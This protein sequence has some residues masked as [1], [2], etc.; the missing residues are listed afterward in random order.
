LY[1]V[2]YSIN[3]LAGYGASRHLVGILGARGCHLR[4]PVEC[5]ESGSTIIAGFD[6][7]VVD[8]DRYSW[9][10]DTFDFVVVLSRHRAESGRKTLSVHHPGNPT[11]EAYGGEPLKLAVAYPALAWKLLRVY[12]RLASEMG[13]EG[14]EVTLEATH[15]GP[16][17]LRP[18]VVFIEV[19]STELEWR[20]EK[21]REAMARAVAETL[22]EKLE[23]CNPVAAIGGPHYPARYTRAS[24][25]SSTCF[26]HI[27]A[28]H[29]IE[30]SSLESATRQAITRNYPKPVEVLVIEKKSLKSSQRAI[31]ERVAAELGVEIEYW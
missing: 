26:G 8:L 22:S 30:D 3:D 31:V 6:V 4:G 24:L 13:L 27:I 5:F 11:R 18:P 21:A 14:Y 25:E 23:Q 2:A 19:G 9:F 15:H 12:A 20:D 17:S 16:T 10:I 29:S 28:R 1:L 7:D